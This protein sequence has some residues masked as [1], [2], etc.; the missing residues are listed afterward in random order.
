MRV[1]GDQLNRA[2]ALTDDGFDPVEAPESGGVPRG[3]GSGG[4]R[5][6]PKWDKVEQSL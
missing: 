5:G 1:P 3:G 6:Q 4:G 2:P